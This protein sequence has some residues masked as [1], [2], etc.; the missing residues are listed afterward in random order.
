MTF[1]ANI[2]CFGHQGTKK[3]SYSLSK[4]CSTLEARIFEYDKKFFCVWKAEYSIYAVQPTIHDK[5]LKLNNLAKKGVRLKF[6]SANLKIEF[7]ECC[8]KIEFEEKRALFG[9]GRG[10]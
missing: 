9:V 6:K 5:K 2:L 8:L 10:A 3:S 1:K 7:E 4:K